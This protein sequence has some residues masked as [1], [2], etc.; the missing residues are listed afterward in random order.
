MLVISSPGSEG[1]VPLAGA[2]D[3][4][5]RLSELIAALSLATDLGMGQPMEHALRTCLLAVRLGERLGLPE[6]ALTDV[7]Y[8][9]LL[10]RVGC[11]SDAFELG[12]LFGDDLAAHARVFA[13][14]FA[15]PLDLLVDLLR[16]AGA[17][18]PLWERA[19][20]AAD[21]VV[22]GP[23]LPAGLFRASCEVAESLAAQ[24]GFGQPILR[25]LTQTFERWDG[26]GV[27]G[28]VRGEEIEL[29]ARVV[30]VAEDAEVASR[31]A[32][33]DG[34][35][36]VV[37]R[38][39][40]ASQDP[41]I[42]ARF[43]H[44][45]ARLLAGLDEGSAWDAVLD[46]EPGHRPR[47]E[48]E[49][50]DA[51]LRAA[52][53]FADLKSPYTAGHST[54]VAALAAAAARSTGLPE[55]DVVGLRR[56]ALVHDLG[57]AGVPNGIWDKRALLSAAEWERVRLHPYFSER[58]LARSEP[59]ARLGALAGLHHERLDGSGYHRG[60]P[61]ALQ[62]PAA[63]IL[64]AADAYHAMTEP[65]PHRPA[66]AP[67]VAVDNLRRE[68]RQGRLD[69]DAVDAVLRAA[70]HRVRRRREWPAGLS[71]REIEVLGLLARGLPNREI[72]RRL[73]VAEPTV[74][75][76]VRH[77]YDKI[78][79]STRAA[80]TLYAMRHDLLERAGSTEI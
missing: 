42:A 45:A 38:R 50:L 71:P 53:H 35:V 29:A 74:A 41:T 11:T 3:P 56:A 28:K 65:R 66:L 78:G 72:A 32:G 16:H 23:S 64:A 79:V 46:A 22:A 8:V 60:V 17:G 69:G 33:P 12:R 34:A 5:L 24:L 27:P 25:A 55:P 4:G 6:A 57:R 9:A 70:G 20:T 67:E 58:V 18:R 76:H 68:V 77:I 48:A 80:A 40:G 26:R 31:L 2:R 14:D 21:A 30:H 43:C 54:G 59:L 62:S 13:L 36:A 63:R 47:L 73:G 15:R 37:R 49:A 10:R 51:A 39:A 52:A 19:Q 61:A 7:Y 44:E 75:A 1:S